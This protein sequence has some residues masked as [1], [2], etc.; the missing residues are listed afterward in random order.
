M[1][2]APKCPYC[3]YPSERV[4]GKAIYRHRP[5]LWDKKFYLC[6]PCDAYVG[7]H[8][9]S[10]MPLGRLADAELRKAKNLAHTAFDPIWKENLM[11]RSNAYGWLS[12]Q[13]NIP[14]HKCH[15]GMFDIETC[16]N[17]VQICNHRRA[18][19]LG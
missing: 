13:L 19:N 15:I 16:K 4:T 7:C 2:I 9:D 10:D 14:K 6:K 8:P 3:G 18:G 17:V 11:S 5:D 12:K 1:S